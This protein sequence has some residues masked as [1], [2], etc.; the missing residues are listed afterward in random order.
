MKTRFKLALVGAIAVALLMVGPKEVDCQQSISSNSKT[1]LLHVAVT[2]DG[3]GGF[4]AGVSRDSFLVLS[5]NVERQ[6]TLFKDGPIPTSICIVLDTTERLS[7]FRTAMGNHVLPALSKGLAEFQNLSPST[8]YS[9]VGVG[10]HPQLLLDW[11]KDLKSVENTVS[12]VEL[13]GRQSALYDGCFTALEKLGQSENQKRVLL[14]VSG[15]SDNKSRRKFSELRRLVREKGYLVYTVGIMDMHGP[16]AEIEGDTQWESEMRELA[17]ISGGLLRV[18]AEADAVLFHFAKLS[19]EFQRQ[20]MI[21]FSTTGELQK[22]EYHKV[23][24]KLRGTQP[25][26]KGLRVRSREGYSANEN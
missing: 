14:I 16:P 2:S 25:G 12:A 10:E 7:L 19:L 21:G 18:A 4:A 17:V 5:D 8:E 9:I 6:I 26:L 15:S 24:V 3:G 13:K 1:V 22:D 20:Y 23:Q 11:T